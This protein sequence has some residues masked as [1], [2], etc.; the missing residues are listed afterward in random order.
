MLTTIQRSATGCTLPA[1]RPP[2]MPPNKALM[3]ITAAILQLTLP[4]N[5]KKMAAP[6]LAAKAMNC[7]SAFSRVS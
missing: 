7:L 5:R 1:S 6:L 2:A 3:A 4:E